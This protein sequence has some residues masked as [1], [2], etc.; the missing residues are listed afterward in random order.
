[1]I[2]TDLTVLSLIYSQNKRS[3]EKDTY[4]IKIQMYFK[5]EI[6]KMYLKTE[7]SCV[8]ILFSLEWNEYTKVFKNK[9]TYMS[10]LFL[11]EWNEYKNIFKDRNYKH[12][13]VVFIWVKWIQNIFKDK[14]NNI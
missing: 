3:A 14:I 10:K 4:W 2:L 13:N 9:I 1:M 5:T 6:K 8:S 7:I 12:F 11:F